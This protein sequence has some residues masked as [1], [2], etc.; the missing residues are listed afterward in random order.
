MSASVPNRFPEGYI[1]SLETLQ[2][3]Q[4][5][6]LEGPELSWVETW[7]SESRLASE[8]A[9]F[10]QPSNLETLSAIT[11][12]INLKVAAQ[13]S[14]ETGSG[15]ANWKSLS[16][17]TILPA[18]LLLGL[19]LWWPGEPAATQSFDSEVAEPVA[20]E[21][22]ISPMKDTDVAEESVANSSPAAQP[23][24]KFSKQTEPA[25]TNEE[26]KASISEPILEPTAVS[27]LPEQEVEEAK[28]E[29]T[30]SDKPVRRRFIEEPK[31]SPILQIVAVEILNIHP[32]DPSERK[33]RKEKRP[34]NPST[35]P[36][37]TEKKKTNRNSSGN[38]AVPEF[39]GGDVGLKDYLTNN[40]SDIQRSKL[41]VD[42]KTIVIRF[43]VTSKGELD[44]L[45]I[46]TPV[47][48][49]VDAEIEKL[50]RNMPRWKPGRNGKKGAVSYT[51]SITLD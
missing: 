38:I 47:M 19:W 32:F 48:P 49:S 50:M 20:K 9:E 35:A 6:E 3:Y 16:L 7:T 44:E 29:K 26:S 17:L 21:S 33:E 45:E 11:E 15:L 18:A 37:L 36:P 43:S 10:V 8:A 40:L 41:P 28:S 5:G 1:P 12:R 39:Y 13:V 27:A 2:R 42:R 23:E 22:P 34:R 30:V 31:R 24:A 14:R 51:V 4:R 46:L 25:S